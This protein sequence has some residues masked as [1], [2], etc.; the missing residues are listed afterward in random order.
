MIPEYRVLR[1]SLTKPVTPKSLILLSADEVKKKI[2]INKKS[3]PVHRKFSSLPSDFDM[4]LLLGKGCKSS[5]NRDEPS[6]LFFSRI[7]DQ[8]PRVNSSNIRIRRKII[9]EIYT[10]TGKTGKKSRTSFLNVKVF[11]NAGLKSCRNCEASNWKN[12]ER[13][14]GDLISQVLGRHG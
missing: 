2:L 6:F 1:G 4:N 7:A 3:K 10:K 5:R 14:Y 13:K 8:E 12:C 11:E 9:N